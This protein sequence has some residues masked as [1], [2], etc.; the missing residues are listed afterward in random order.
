MDITFTK[1]CGLP[2]LEKS[3]QFNA[4]S[5]TVT[6]KLHDV[7]LKHHDVTL[8]LSSNS[9]MSLTNWHCVKFTAE[10]PDEK[11]SRKLTLVA[12]VIQTL[13]NFTRL[14]YQSSPDTCTRLWCA[15]FIT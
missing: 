13:A 1:L 6:P 8:K 11:T 5:I 4:R 3:C 12:K 14:G 2:T 9:V 15:V 10:Y 7:T